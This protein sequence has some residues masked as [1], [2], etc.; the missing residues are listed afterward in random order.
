MRQPDPRSGPIHDLVLVG[1]GHTHIQVLK[2]WAMAPVAGVRVTVVVDRPVAVYSGMVPGFVAGQYRREELEIDVRPLAMRAGARFVAATAVGIDPGER[3]LRVAGRP[4][5]PYDTASF[6]VGSTVAGL[7]LPGVREHALPTRP[8]GRFVERVDD[9]VAGARARGAAR[10]VVVGA[11]AGGVE[12]AFAL[13][14]RLAREG[15]APAE[16]TLLDGGSRVLPGYP[17]TTARR[18]ERHAAA[19]HIA[20]RLGARVAEVRPDHVRLESGETIAFDA[21]VWVGG[22]RS[23]ERRGGK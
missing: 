19:R 11:G 22:A 4:P 9:L 12:L 21:P 14:A 10:V 17:Q 6:D 5:I 13:R 2:S 23:E 3:R 16:I 1:G 18:I 15:V 8:I 20:V 7:D